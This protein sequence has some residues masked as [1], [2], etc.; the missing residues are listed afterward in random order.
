MVD[1]FLI[2]E[3]FLPREKDSWRFYKAQFLGKKIER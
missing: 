1:D 2:L 3:N